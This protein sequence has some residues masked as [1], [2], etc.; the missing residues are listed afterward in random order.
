[1]IKFLF[2]LVVGIGLLLLAGYLFATRGGLFMGTKG[3]PL[4]MERSV[5]KKALAASIGQS[6]QDQS[7]LPADETNLLA[8]AQVYQHNCA[9]CHGRLDQPALEMAKRFYPHVPQLLP[10]SKGV[11]DDPVGVTH[12]VVKNGIRFSAMP[13]F[14]GKL[15]DPELWQVSLFLHDADKLPPPVQ[16]VLRP[17][18]AFARCYGGPGKSRT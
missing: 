9:G 1:M 7:P 2:G 3:G 14:E 4:P 13:S 5:A 18:A 11:T 15:T 12:W 6:S 16:E 10:P 17:L 8:G